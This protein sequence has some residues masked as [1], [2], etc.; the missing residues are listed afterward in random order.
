MVL[1]RIISK[2][3][4][5]ERVKA[6]G[7]KMKKFLILLSISISCFASCPD[8]SLKGTPFSKE[9][10]AINMKIYK[11]VLK[12]YHQKDDIEEYLSKEG[13]SSLRSTNI[14]GTLSVLSYIVKQDDST[15]KKYNLLLK[16]IDFNNPKWCRSEVYER[17]LSGY[18]KVKVD[19][20]DD[21]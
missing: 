18:R 13:F 16:N 12:A 21:D 4:I 10:S 9:P 19:A 11:D 6:K 20:G 3:F 14:W 15:R 17:T 2:K 1:F 5:R 8:L 7:V